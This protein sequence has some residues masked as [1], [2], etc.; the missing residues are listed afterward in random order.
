[1]KAQRGVVRL[2]VDANEVYENDGPGLWCDGD[3]RDVVFSSNRI[4]GNVQAGIQY[5][6]SH[7]ARIFN[8]VI[9]KNGI[10]YRLDSNHWGWGA[11]ILVQNSNG[12]QVFRNT[13]AWN[14]N[15]IVVLE[16]DRGPAYLVF[17]TSVHDNTIVSQDAQ[18]DGL[19]YALAWLSDH[20][21]KMFAPSQENTASSNRYGYSGAAESAS[22]RF[23][24]SAGYGRLADFNVT[25]G[26]KG[27]AYLNVTEQKSVLSA[28]RVPLSP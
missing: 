12:C 24:W 3:C 14:A 15:G 7:D 27:G 22:V 17:N 25:P 5:E 18:A 4:H 26:G 21:T 13:L 23:A 16:Q 1:L 11:A 2:T 8:N 28:V 6:I 9:W 20:P 19:I 10:G